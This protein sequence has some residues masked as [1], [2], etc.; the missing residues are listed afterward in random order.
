VQTKITH[1]AF[2]EL[3]LA[4]LYEIMSLRQAVFIVE[5]TCPYQD[6]DDKDQASHHVMIYDSSNK[7]AAYARV[8]PPGLSYAEYSSIGRVVTSQA[9]RGKGLGRLLMEVYILQFYTDLG[10]VAQGEEYL[11]DDIPHKA[12]VLG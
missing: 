10:F 6:A 8:V 1:K 5:Q 12:R 2:A 4:E 7:L 11:E 3:D 9:S